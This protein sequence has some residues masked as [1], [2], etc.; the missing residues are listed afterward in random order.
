MTARLHVV[1]VNQDRGIAPHRQKGAAVHLRAMREAFSKL[2]ARVSTV[3]E[4][5]G[6]RAMFLLH[7]IHRETPIDLIYERYALGKSA[8]AEFARAHGI[9]LALEVNA[10]LAEEQSRWREQG[11][12]DFDAACDQVTFGQAD[13]ILA[14]ST[15][16]ADYALKRGGRP[17][18]VEVIPN[19]IDTS[20]FN[21]EA[22]PGNGVRK[23]G[24][25]DPFVVGFHGRERPWHCFDRLV[26]LV[27][28]LHD[29][30]KPV[31]LKVIGMGEFSALERLPESIVTRLSWV[32]HEQL[33][34][35]LATLDAMP[36]TYS[37]DLPCYFSPL[38]LM[39]G[40]ACGVVPLVPDLGDLPRV[41][42]HE[43][44]GLVYPPGEMD[45]LLEDVTSLIDDRQSCHRLALNAA[46]TAARR[47]WQNIART[48]LD[49]VFTQQAG[50]ASEGAYSAGSR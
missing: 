35:H 3:D 32:D 39:E 4:D 37:P 34:S 18:A 8:A 27:G 41:V 30:G 13:Y 6:A 43:H 24:P 21:L 2:G 40:M 31:R 10:P 16:V 26:D 20:L 12:A 38:K 29:R 47:D 7:G 36:F 50:L 9:P 28:I 44:D 17:G 42:H 45:A 11:D 25:D 19:G 49:S 33:P 1:S 22:R 15:A 23:T 5:N 48:V 14:V 46:Q